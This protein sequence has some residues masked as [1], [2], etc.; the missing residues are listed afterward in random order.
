MLPIV[1]RVLVLH[2][3]TKVSERKVSSNVRSGIA[4]Y[5]VTGPSK[6]RARYMMIWRKRSFGGQLF[7][8]SLSL[9][10]TAYM[11]KFVKEFLCSKKTTSLTVV[12]SMI[13]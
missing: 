11:T 12:C 5:I 6:N 13:D 8:L 3:I 7:L 4:R 2:P 9:F 10:F 1:W